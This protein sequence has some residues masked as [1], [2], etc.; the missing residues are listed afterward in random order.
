MFDNFAADWQPEAGTLGFVRHGV[1]ALTE[2]FENNAL[3]LQRNTWPIVV[4]G[5]RGEPIAGFK[6]HRHQPRFGG[7]KFHRIGEQVDKDLFGSIAIHVNLHSSIAS[8]Q[9]EKELGTA[10]AEQA[11]H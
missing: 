4:H 11:G 2:S 6:R 1:T 10:F 8:R 9:I 5:N 3:V 7:H